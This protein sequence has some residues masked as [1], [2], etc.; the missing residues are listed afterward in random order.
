MTNSETLASNVRCRIW[1]SGTGR[2]PLRDDGRKASMHRSSIATT[3]LFS[4]FSHS[5]GRTMTAPHRS[6]DK[7]RD[8]QE[9]D[10]VGDSLVSVTR[11]GY[12]TLSRSFS[13]EMPSLPFSPRGVAVDGMGMGAEGGVDETPSVL[14][15]EARVGLGGP[16]LPTGR[17]SN[18]RLVKESS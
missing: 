6:D 9:R 7:R 2:T 8:D 17:P 18:G 14:E 13:D 15:R 10:F 1:A 5:S 16:L 3:R 11:P 4:P 12:K